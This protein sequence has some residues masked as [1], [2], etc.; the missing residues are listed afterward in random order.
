MCST[1]KMQVAF[2]L[3]LKTF[4]KISI[5]VLSSL[6]K[7]ASEYCS[8][9]DVYWHSGVFLHAHLTL[10]RT[11]YRTMGAQSSHRSFQLKFHEFLDLPYGINSQKY[12]SWPP[13]F[14]FFSPSMLL[15][16]AVCFSS[17]DYQRATLHFFFILSWIFKRNINLICL[18]DQL[19]L[20]LL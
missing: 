16:G 18:K 7:W 1:L 10:G 20:L 17:L 3:P 13:A 19:T 9:N 6:W 14:F 8:R 15:L 11:R 4:W 2:F 5:C 12:L